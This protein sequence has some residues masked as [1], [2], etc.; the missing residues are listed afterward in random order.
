[1]PIDRDGRFA[2]RNPGIRG[3]RLSRSPGKGTITSPRI[4]MRTLLFLLACFLVAPAT[5]QTVASSRPVTRIDRNHSTIGF[6]VPIAGGVGTVTGKFS[7]F[8]IDLVWNAG[9]LDSSRVVLEIQAASIDT[10]IADRDEHLRSEDFFDVLKHPVLR[11]ESTSISGSG[12][13]YVVHG[14]LRMRGVSREVDLPLE[15]TT[16][17]DPMEGHTWTAFRVETVLDR[18]DYG[19]S[20]KHGAIEFFVGDDIT[21]DITLMSR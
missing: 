14:T 9:H 11:F 17:T 19:I 5:A 15:V 3:S 12:S 16:F 13:A 20:W 6:R 21:T 8:A 18:M 1:M 10:G 2:R 7:E 4:E